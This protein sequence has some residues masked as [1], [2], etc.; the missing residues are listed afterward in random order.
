[1]RLCWID[2]YIGPPEL[3]THD[4]G[5][6]FIS[7]EFRQYAQS[8]AITTK[9]VPVEAHWSVG[10]VERAHPILRRA[11]KIITKECSGI[12]KEMALQMAVKAI[13]DTAGPNGLVPTLLVFGAYPRMTDI[14]STPS[15]TERAAA[16]HKAMEEVT[17]IRAQI[18]VKEA[19]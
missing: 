19:L 1:L 2:T 7:R 10:L 17:K 15:I 5:K 4:A 13:N 14:D 12:T 9:S 18:Q 3:I 16:I 11:Y 8:L 6:N